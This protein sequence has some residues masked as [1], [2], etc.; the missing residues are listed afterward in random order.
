MVESRRHN[1]CCTKSHKQCRMVYKMGRKAKPVAHKVGNV[2]R[3]KA[4]Q[5]QIRHG[6]AKQGTARQGAEFFLRLEGV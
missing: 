1:K 4:R 3:K 2:R 5:G 6:K